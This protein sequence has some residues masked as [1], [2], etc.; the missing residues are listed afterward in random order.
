MV[1]TSG[2]SAD[3]IGEAGASMTASQDDDDLFATDSE[4]ASDGSESDD[5]GSDRSQERRI[6]VN[7]LADGHEGALVADSDASSSLPSNATSAVPSSP[8]NGIPE[9]TDAPT[10]QPIRDLT[11]K[12]ASTKQEIVIL[13]QDLDGTSVPKDMKSLQAK[14]ILKE[15]KLSGQEASLEKL[16]QAAETKGTKARAKVTHACRLPRSRPYTRA[17]FVLMSSACHTQA[18]LVLQWSIATAFAVS[19]DKCCD[20]CLLTPSVSLHLQAAKV[21]AAAQEKI[22]NTW[23]DEQEK[24]LSDMRWNPEGPFYRRFNNKTERNDVVLQALTA[25]FNLKFSLSKHIST[26][27]EK[28]RAIKSQFTMYVNQRNRAVN[29]S[30]AGVEDV[31]LNAMVWWR[32]WTPLLEEWGLDKSDDVAAPFTLDC[33]SALA[34]GKARPDMSPGAKKSKAKRALS[35][36][37]E[38]EPTPT[39]ARNMPAHLVGTSSNIIGGHS[40]PTHGRPASRQASVA[41]TSSSSE[42][43]MDLTTLLQS[44]REQQRD[45]AEAADKQ[46]ADDLLVR[47]Q[48]MKGELEDRVA[49]RQHE[50]DMLAANTAA[51]AQA[52]AANHS[53]MLALIDRIKPAASGRT[54]IRLPHDLCLLDPF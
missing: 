33:D 13:K 17:H 1:V 21:Q 11:G 6:G 22:N 14:I 12:I 29:E 32:P 26:V 39:K 30:G 37:E 5:E 38:Y 24:E 10:T 40:K 25:A 41:R 23:S 16:R 48:Q 7:A 45:R 8:S 2:E 34:G 31:P 49:Q 53:F 44:T 3:G 27:A 51:N 9:R 42:E 43:P 28:I 18:P 50:K 47:Q 15:K 35:D 46:R 20:A 4:Q 19:L 52:A 36:C 54:H